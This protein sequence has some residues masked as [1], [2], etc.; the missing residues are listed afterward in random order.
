MARI[1]AEW[2]KDSVS[3]RITLER[4][5]MYDDADYDSKPTPLSIDTAMRRRMLKIVRSCLSID[6]P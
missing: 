6:S 1:I 3:F 2:V 4:V 5:H